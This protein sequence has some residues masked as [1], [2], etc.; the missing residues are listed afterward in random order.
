MTA[1]HGTAAQQNDG[2]G[3]KPIT[4]IQ[5]RNREKI[6]RGALEAFSANGFNGTS[7]E[8][9]AA[10]AGMS[11][12]NLLYYFPNKEAVY[13][14]VVETQLNGWLGELGRLNPD[15]NPIDEVIAYVHRKVDCARL[16][17]LETRLYTNEIL[18]GGQ[19]IGDTI[20]TVQK[21][22]I[23][24]QVAILKKWM[25]EGHIR[26]MDP[27]HLI[28]SIWATTEHYAVFDMQVRQ[29]GDPA[30]SEIA[31]FAEIKAFLTEFFTRVIR[32]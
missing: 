20:S 29:L 17:P 21:P 13:K 22:L 1:P 31:R 32:P 30:K 19:F 23:D 9:I 27:H 5:K 25:D 15:G 12:Q 2:T 24:A 11:K 6:L 14:I 16:R 7:I 3:E 10:R 4:R 18:S 28:F 26:K 8:D